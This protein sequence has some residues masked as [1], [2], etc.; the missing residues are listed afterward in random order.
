MKQFKDLEHTA[1]PNW[2]G[3]SARMFFDNGYGVSVIKS[4]TSQGAFGFGGS[5]GG[6]EGLYELAVLK[7]DSDNSKLTYETPV[8]DDVVGYLSEEGV[9]EYMRKVQELPDEE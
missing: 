1:H 6:T 2:S 9:T 7:G 8:T 3:T 4:D 5:Y